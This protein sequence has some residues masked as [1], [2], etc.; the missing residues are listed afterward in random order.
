M[1]FICEDCKYEID[2]D[3]DEFTVLDC[4]ECGG[5]MYAMEG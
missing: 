5:T 2:C 1:I 4:D 3:E